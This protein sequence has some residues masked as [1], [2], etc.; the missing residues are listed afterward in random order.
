MAEDKF[1]AYVSSYTMGES[2]PYGIRTFDVDV[3]NGRMTAKQ[4]IPITNSSYISISHNRK[5]LYSITD[6]GV[7]AYKLSADGSLT[8]LGGTV[9]INGMRGCYLSTDY[10]DRFLFTGGF[11]D[12][13]I[14]VL[15][16][17][18]DGSV[19]EITD[20]IFHKGIG[21]IGESTFRPHVTCVKMTR[22]NKYLL[23]A[24][25]GTDYTYV[26]RFHSDKGKLEPVDIIRSDQ[27]SGPRHIKISV[28]GRFVYIVQEKKNAIDVYS[29]EEKNG[30]PEFERIQSVSTLN[31]YHSSVCA[32]SALNL[33]RDCNYIISSNAG[34]N[35]VVAFKIDRND[36]TLKKMFCLPISG[37]YP[38]DAILYPDN[39]HLVSVNHESE[40]MTLFKVDMDKGVI[41][42][43]GPAIK[44][45][46]P[47]CIIIHR[48]GRGSTAKKSV[49]GEE[50]NDE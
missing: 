30:I 36:G 41:M 29:Y 19:G 44:V 33:S 7:E 21:S 15:K 17:K 11:H 40:T 16:L 50:I 20:E 14:T 10:N 1:V 18:S 5:I 25:L 49:K 12:G 6:M 42:M 34:D 26:Y 37:E 8:Q 23:A 35:S 27:N 45:P 32:T 47:N 22:D 9:P 28:D 43:N 24:D 3:K 4:T 39:K 13:K 46:R 38:K 48:I 2:E 31:E